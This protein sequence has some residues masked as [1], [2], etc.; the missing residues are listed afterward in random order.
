MAK[1]IAWETY[2]RL[3]RP[4]TVKVN[5]TALSIRLR[6][7]SLI[8]LHG[9]DNP[10]SLVG[11]G[12]DKVTLDEFPLL[13]E[14]LW[15]VAIRPALAD[16]QGRALF[17][18]SPRGFNWAYDVYLHGQNPDMSD[19]ASWQ[20]TTLQGGRVTAQ[21]IEAARSGMDPRLFK[22]E[23]EASFETLLGRV[24]ANFDRKPWPLGNIEAVEDQPGSE[25]L[26]GM[27]FNVHPM[28]AVIAVQA[29]DECHVLDALEVPT[30][31]TEEMAQELRT[32][33][34]GRRII[35]YP[36]PSGRARKTSAPVGQTDFTILQ[37][38]G[39]QVVAPNVAPLVVDRVNN[40]QAMLLDAAGRRRLKIHPRAVRLTRALEGLTYKEGTSLPDKTLGLDH[41][42]DAL[43]YL[44]WERFNL[45]RQ[46]LTV[47][48]NPL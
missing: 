18:G 16:K 46:R 44:L 41:L 6:N 7:D 30:S 12:L 19:W 13:D 15:N 39:F 28:T 47:T 11:R 20:F 25:L 9:A 5:E 27:D 36:D 31:N 37:R 22:Q 45:L 2:K 32:R 1:D 48:R 21:E 10:D 26:I 8:T 43:G 38:A 4:W 17:I 42:G 3:A 24:Y 23:F 29:A 33:Y 14:K 40:T 34:P 35:V